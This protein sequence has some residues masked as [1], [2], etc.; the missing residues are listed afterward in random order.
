MT[1]EGD[2]ARAWRDLLTGADPS[3]HRIRRIWHRIPSAPRCKVCASPFHG[4]GGALARLFWHGPAR[5]NPLLCQACFGTLASHPGGA[6]IEISVLFADVRGSTGLAEHESAGAF[7]RLIQ[8]YYVIAAQAVDRFG[9]VVDKYLGDGVMALFVPVLAG[10][11]HAGRAVDAGLAILD[12]VR[13]AGLPARGAR[14]GVGVH[15]G[16]AFVGVLGAGDKL[17]FT[18]LGD[19][20]NVAARLGALA[21]GGELLV[22]LDAWAG[23]GAT[24]ARATTRAIEI[25]GRSSGLEVVSVRLEDEAA[26]TR[27]R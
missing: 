8:D 20:V 22:S 26:S 12:D 11:D 4:P 10:E 16:P 6:E 25:P 18:A 9:G 19:T 1:D 15:A 21:S 17:D 7:R 24:D 13:R 14:V 3:L 2:E 23:R 27:S 5:S